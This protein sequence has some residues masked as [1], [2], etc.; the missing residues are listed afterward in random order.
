MPTYS[1]PP[2]TIEQQIRL[3]EQRGLIVANRKLA[4]KVLS[5]CNFY[6]FGGYAI[7]FWVTPTVRPQQYLTGTRFEDVLQI[8]D[9]DRELRM[10]TLDVIERLEVSVRSIITSR[11]SLFYRSPHWYLEGSRFKSRAQHADF[12]SRRAKDFNR[13]KEVFAVHYKKRYTDPDLPPSWVIA[14]ITS[15]GTWSHLFE[16][17]SSRKLRNRIA[18]VFGL[19]HLRLE[20]NLHVLNVTRNLCAHHS[21]I[22]NRSFAFKP[23]L[24]QSTVT[25]PIPNNQR[26]AA[27]AGMMWVMLR[28][29]EPSSDWT[30]KLRDLFVRYHIQPSTLGFPVGWETD[31]FWGI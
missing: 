3:L 14:E 24:S 22:W 10:L 5:T 27:Q 1:K 19:D 25:I 4:K 30:R 7:H 20:N 8:M 15:L 16:N 18:G 9:F 26:F 12:V 6:R 31:P 21:R 23:S 29:I 11:A 17:L 28:A 13:S 2:L